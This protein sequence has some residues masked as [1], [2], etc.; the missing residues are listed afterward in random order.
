MRN[1]SSPMS[2]M[3]SIF[4]LILDRSALQFPMHANGAYVT[5]TGHAV[6]GNKGEGRELQIVE[7]GPFVIFCPCPLLYDKCTYVLLSPSS[8][9][10][11]HG[12]N[13]MIKGARNPHFCVW[14]PQSLLM[15]LTTSLSYQPLNM[16]FFPAYSNELS[17]VFHIDIGL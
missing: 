6:S 11:T 17:N 3:S 9:Y 4:Q 10:T 15:P 13:K 16:T 5:F 12:G 8:M 1:S 2:G 7:C 14:L